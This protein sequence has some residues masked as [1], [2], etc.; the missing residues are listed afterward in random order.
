MG[1]FRE[2]LGYAPPILRRLATGKNS[3]YHY[4]AAIHQ[5]LAES[6]ENDLNV[7]VIAQHHK[8]NVIFVGH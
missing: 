3:G 5:P 8:T 4:P 7:V 6:V 1:R 2:L